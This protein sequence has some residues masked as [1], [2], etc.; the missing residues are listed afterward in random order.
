MTGPAHNPPR[1]CFLKFVIL[2]ILLLTQVACE[3]SAETDPPV[4]RVSAL[5][6]QIPE[7]VRAQ[8]GP[9]IDYVC[10][11]AGV[12]C[13][14]VESSS[15]L[16]LVEKFT[17]GEIDLVYFGGVTFVMA[18]EISAAVPLVMRDIDTRFSS[19]IFVRSDDLASS[20]EEL[21]GHSFGFGTEHS[22]SGHYMPRHFLRR[23]GVEPASFFGSVIH[24]SGHDDTLNRIARGDIDSGVVNMQIARQMLLVQ[25]LDL[26]LVWETAPYIDYVWAVRPGLSEDL[27]LA[28]RDAFLSLRSSRGEERA[29]LEQ[30]GAQ[31][32]L[33]ASVEDFA[34][35]RQIIKA[36]KEHEGQQ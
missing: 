22:T 10:A 17:G 26:R 16:D 25:E 2:V 23:A 3:F 14:W 33:P 35:L 18:S 32:F 1:P 13:R 11:N 29:I 9:L 5:P 4:L 12:Q 7:A 21:E 8:H 6:D 27:R 34:E 24:S 36:H 30:Q 19:G 31:G 28:L 15:Y 20:L